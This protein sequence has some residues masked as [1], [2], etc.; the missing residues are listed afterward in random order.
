MS[1]TICSKARVRTVRLVREARAM[2]ESVFPPTV[3]VNERHRAS[4]SR[5]VGDANVDRSDDVQ[6]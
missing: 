6:S 5:A 2:Y 4:T 1:A 3:A